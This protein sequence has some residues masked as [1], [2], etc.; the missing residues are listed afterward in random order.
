MATIKHYYIL[1]D[2]LYVGQ[3]WA[4]SEAE[5]VKNYWWRVVKKNN[6]FQDRY[7]NPS[8]FEAISHTA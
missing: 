4:T 1:L 8:D 6:P 7:L 3:T 5:A 2:G